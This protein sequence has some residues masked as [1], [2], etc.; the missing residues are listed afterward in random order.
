M[1]NAMTG[2]RQALQAHQVDEQGQPVNGRYFRRLQKRYTPDAA[3]ASVLGDA[4]GAAASNSSRDVDGAAEVAGEAAP[5][6]AS[7]RVPVACINLLRCNMQ[8]RD[9]SPG[10]RVQRVR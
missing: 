6:D 8:A 9:D 5:G 2:N 10:R 1:I 3:V 7:L 4:A